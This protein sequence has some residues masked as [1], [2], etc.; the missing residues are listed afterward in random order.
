MPDL[1]REVAWFID[2]GTV[3]ETAEVN[4]SARE[5]GV[6]WKGRRRL[7]CGEALVRGRNRLKIEVANLWIHHVLAHD[8]ADPARQLRGAGPDAA[9]AETVGIRWGTY[10][11]VPPTEVPPAGLLGPVRL[12]PMKKVR[13]RL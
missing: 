11:E 6:A 9:L 1:G 7:A 10:G 2:L 3:H 8:P 4:L 12:I 13:A 5:L